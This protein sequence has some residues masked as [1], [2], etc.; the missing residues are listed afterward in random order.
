[1]HALHFRFGITGP[2]LAFQN[3]GNRSEITSIRGPRARV[4]AILI[5]SFILSP[6]TVQGPAAR[7]PAYSDEVSWH[8]PECANYSLKRGTVHQ[9][10]SQCCKCSELGLVAQARRL[11]KCV[12]DFFPSPRLFCYCTD[13]QPFVHVQE[14][15]NILGVGPCYYMFEAMKSS[16][17]L[18]LWL[19][20]E[21][22]VRAGKE[23]DFSRCVAPSLSAGRLLVTCFITF[24]ANLY[25]NKADFVRLLA[26]YVNCETEVCVT[27]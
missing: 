4:G 15:L 14:A 24:S 13:S 2:R 22:A 12:L 8:I 1:M 27:S 5:V 23:F 21:A 25:D 18:G 26:L 6:S 9:S 19:E 10:C 7:L 3:V 20:A 16:R 11:S 17:D